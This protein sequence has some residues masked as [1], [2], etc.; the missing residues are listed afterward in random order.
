MRLSV[1][2]FVFLASLRRQTWLNTGTGGGRDGAEMKERASTLYRAGGRMVA[3]CRFQ[4]RRCA[5]RHSYPAPAGALCHSPLPTD[6]AGLYRRECRRLTLS[7]TSIPRDSGV[8]YD[9]ARFS[10]LVPTNIFMLVT[11]WADATLAGAERGGGGCQRRKRRC[12]HLP[13]KA[14]PALAQ[15]RACGYPTNGGLHFAP[16]A[17]CCRPFIPAFQQRR[18]ATAL[19][20]RM[21]S[22]A[23]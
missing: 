23:C 15:R 13:S 5:W 17:F 9:G 2:C 14:A 19:L 6:A 3:F 16:V 8:P 10:T 21:A 11:R 1:L 4:W 7:A 22:K 12:K 20:H 18:R